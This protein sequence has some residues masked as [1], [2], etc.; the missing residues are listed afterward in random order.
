MPEVAE[1][2]Q[3]EAVASVAPV[4]ANPFDETSWTSQQPAQ[5]V[6]E[7]QPSQE[8]KQDDKK[9]TPAPPIESD[10]FIDANDYLK[11]QLGFESW[12]VAKTELQ[13]LRDLRE[14]G[15]TQ[16]EIKFANEQSQKLFDAWREGK[17]DDVYSYLHQQRYLD[18]LEKLELTNVDEAAEIIKAN[19][20]F[21]YKDLTPKQIDRLYNKEYALPIQP[22]Q[23]LEE[24]DEDYKIRVDEWKLKVQEKEE[25]ILINAKI[26]K[27]EL[28][29]FKSELVLPDISNRS[30][31]PEAPDPKVLERQEQERRDFYLKTVDSEYKN[32]NGFEAK[33]K[34]ESGDLPITF[35][36]P[37]EEKVVFAN[38][39]KDFDFNG[40]FE[41]RWFTNGKANV[42]QMMSDLYLLENPGKVFQGLS[43]NAGSAVLDNYLKTKSNIKVDGGASQTNGFQITAKEAQMK[44]EEALW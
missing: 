21:K 16:S 35:N 41:S 13:Q 36:V 7:S 38:K 11:Q 14:K 44:Q 42:S 32:F 27:P 37:D 19:L 31:Q 18:R 9:D 15:G 34:T 17:M 29:K 25:D 22:R 10:E 24:S 3:P 33:V 2:K 43:N 26:A 30:Q 12:D 20:Q 39:L 23:E 5:S 28:I 8:I 40:Y 6:Q 1:Q 4:E